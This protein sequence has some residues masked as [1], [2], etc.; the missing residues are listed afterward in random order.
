MGLS[1]QSQQSE[2]AVELAA[3]EPTEVAN[4]KRDGRTSA[5]QSDKRPKR[6]NS[7]S[8][9]ARRES[10]SRLLQMPAR[11]APQ[12]PTSASRVNSV[13]SVKAAPKV[14]SSSRRK[15]T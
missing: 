7:L 4:V 8:A 14:A 5:S 3:A 6:T 15:M 10:V 2:E 9:E 13:S 11:R 1:E 12:R